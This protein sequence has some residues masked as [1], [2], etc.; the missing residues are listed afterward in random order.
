MMRFFFTGERR[1][2]EEKCSS[3]K[4]IITEWIFETSEM[5]G[6]IQWSARYWSINLKTK[7]KTR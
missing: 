2:E 5:T 6:I 7:Q 3:R 1:G 4:E